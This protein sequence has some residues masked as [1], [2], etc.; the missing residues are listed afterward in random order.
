MTKIILYVVADARYL[1]SP[2]VA[3]CYQ[4]ICHMAEK[5][6][7]PVM[8]IHSAEPL[9]YCNE[10]P[11]SPPLL[12]SPDPL[13]LKD[14]SALLSSHGIKPITMGAQIPNISGVYIDT[15]AILQAV[16][17]HLADAG[18]ERIAF[19][20]ADRLDAYQQAQCIAFRAQSSHPSFFMDDSPLDG[21]FSSLS[22]FDALVCPND[23][24]ALYLLAELSKRGQELAIVGC[25]NTLLSTH[26][27]PTLTT[28]ATDFDQ[29]GMLAFGLWQ[30]MQ[31][32]PTLTAFNTT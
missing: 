1:T 14:T 21:F 26:V 5:K 27:S 11:I 23:A 2:F 22:G 19:V 17:A 31:S 6:H 28:T 9:L 12:L 4:G 15:Q 25:G 8:R 13:W 24:I 20:G 32:M 3:R 18:F 10:I 29:L 30:L 16:L 7:I